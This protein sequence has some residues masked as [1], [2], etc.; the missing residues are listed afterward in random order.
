[1]WGELTAGREQWQGRDMGRY[2]IFW[3]VSLRGDET[4]LE[5]MVVMVV[6][7]VSVLNTSELYT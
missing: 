6:Q 7:M 1:M 4:V 3:A 2:S 5:W